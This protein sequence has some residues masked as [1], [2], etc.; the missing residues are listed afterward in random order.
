MHGSI[1]VL[2]SFSHRLGRAVSAYARRFR[3]PF[4]LIVA[5]GAGGFTGAG[6]AV[7]AGFEVVVFVGILTL[8]F[9]TQYNF[10]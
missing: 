2:P 3:F 6:V 4:F 9:L 10:T 5:D 7:T 1:D 8:D